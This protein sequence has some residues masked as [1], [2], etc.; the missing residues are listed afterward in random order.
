MI[1][2]LLL[3]LVLFF[4]TD[5]EIFNTGVEAHTQ[6]STFELNSIFHR[7]LKGY[8]L[9]TISSQGYINSDN[10]LLLHKPLY[11]HLSLQNGG[12]HILSLHPQN[13]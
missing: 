1:I 5:K 8:N 9:V 6:Y 12:V 7:Q 13:L 4:F 2:I 10:L 3:V 11:Y